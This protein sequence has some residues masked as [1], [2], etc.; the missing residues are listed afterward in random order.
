M[1]E[2]VVWMLIGHGVVLYMTS[3]LAL[4]A[5]TLLMVC[6]GVQLALPTDRRLLLLRCMAS[7]RWLVCMTATGSTLW[8]SVVASN[9]LEVHGEPHTATLKVWSLGTCS[10]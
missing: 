3:E 2:G 8:G 6:V 7:C 5:L 1:V 9:C 10:L 4:Q